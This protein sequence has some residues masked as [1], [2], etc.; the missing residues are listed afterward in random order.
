MK[1]PGLFF[2]A[3][4]FCACQNQPSGKAGLQDSASAVTPDGAQKNTDWNRT[5][6]VEYIYYPDPA[7][8]KE[9]KTRFVKD[10]ELLQVLTANLQDPAVEKQVC[11]H[12]AKFY[13]FHK[14]EVFKT[15]YVSDSCN[16]LAYA[17]NSRQQFIELNA[18]TKKMLDSLRNAVLKD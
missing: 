4:L 17:V 14:G 10:K 12:Y 2:I 18:A 16:Y 1:I 5:D 7:K 8:Q 11:P 3:F 15:V 6:S 13:L 9:Y